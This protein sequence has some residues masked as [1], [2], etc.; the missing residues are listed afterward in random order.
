MAAGAE[1]DALARVARIGTRVEEL[2][3][4]PGDVDQTRRAGCPRGMPA[5]GFRVK[6][7]GIQ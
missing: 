6:S 5:R 4:E 2:M 1:V 3:L 7:H